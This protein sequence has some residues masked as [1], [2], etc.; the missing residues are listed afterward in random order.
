MF[1]GVAPF[2]R[3]HRVSEVFFWLCFIVPTRI[4]LVVVLSGI[5][6]GS[7]KHTKCLAGVIYVIATESGV[8]GSSIVVVATTR[9]I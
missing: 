7:Y 6:Q 2:G 9:M 1:Q 4:V 8:G 5:S 3:I